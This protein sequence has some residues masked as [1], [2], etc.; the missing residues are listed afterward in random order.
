MGRQVCTDVAP[1]RHGVR[2]GGPRVDAD[3]G[4]AEAACR[5]RCYNQCQPA[6]FWL[7]D[8]G[9]DFVRRAMM[10]MMR[11]MAMIVMDDDGDYSDG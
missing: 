6:R 9:S 4:E 3:V 8:N 10:R 11:M 5:M 2:R 7:I 1:E